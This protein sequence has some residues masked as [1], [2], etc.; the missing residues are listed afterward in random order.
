MNDF[1]LKACQKR[2]VFYGLRYPVT[3]TVDGKCIFGCIE[4]HVD[5]LDA[6]LDSEV[7]AKG[8]ASGLAW[9]LRWKDMLIPMC[10]R[11]VAEQQAYWSRDE[12]A[13]NRA[14]DLQTAT[15]HEHAFDDFRPLCDEIKESNGVAHTIAPKF[16]KKF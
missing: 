15:D 3:I 6:V 12:E 14:A 7:E 16:E 2:V 10:K 4:I 11:V 1:T 13:D 9:W 8:G 5:D